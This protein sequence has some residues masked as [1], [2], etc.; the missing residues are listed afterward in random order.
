MI[1]AALQFAE[2]GLRIFPCRPCSKLPA[3]PHGVLDAT[4]DRATIE[5]WWRHQAD[6]QYR[7]CLRRGLPDFCP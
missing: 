5:T 6:L 7:R 3:S 1:R 4:A 2:Q